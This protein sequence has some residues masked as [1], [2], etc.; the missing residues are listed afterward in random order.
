MPMKE[1]LMIVWRVHWHLLG[2]GLIESKPIS[3]AEITYFADGSSF[4]DHVGSHTGYSIIMKNGGNFK[5]SYL[6]I[7]RNRVPLN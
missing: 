3:V 6:R 2:Y 1:C 7:V 4:R 5:P